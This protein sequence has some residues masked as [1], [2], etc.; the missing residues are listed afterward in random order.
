MHNI[1]KALLL[2]ILVLPAVATAQTA[3]EVFDS[4]YGADLKKV[5]GSPDTRDDLALAERM[6][7][8]IRSGK[9]D[10]QAAA[11]LC[12]KGFDLA[13]K[14]PGG[15][16]TAVA[17]M[18]E[19][20]ARKPDQK[21]PCLEKIAD[22]REKAFRLTP[23]AFRLEAGETLIDSLIEAAEADVKAGQKAQAGQMLDRALS[24]G[25]AIGSLRLSGLREWRR[26]LQA[27]ESNARRKARLQAQI[28]EFPADHAARADLVRLCLIEMDD[29]AE[30]RKYLEDASQESW[31]TYLPLACAAPDSLAEAACLEVADWYRGLADNA[32]AAG[33][34]A[35][36]VRAKGYYEQYL[37]MHT[38]ADLGHSKAALALQKIDEPLAAMEE[39]GLTLWADLLKPVLAQL[40]GNDRWTVKDGKARSSNN[41]AGRIDFAAP[42]DGGF[43]VMARFLKES[44]GDWG[45]AM[46]VGK[47]AAAVVYKERVTRRSADYSLEM[48]GAPGA[49]AVAL[50][51]ATPEEYLLHVIVALQGKNAE[52]TV[53]LNGKRALHW[54]G[55]A[56][57]VNMP[58][59]KWHNSRAIGL[60]T[61]GQ[62][63]LESVRVRA[64]TGKPFGSAATRPAGQPTS[65]PASQGS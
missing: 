44:G 2:G 49:P 10:A 36:L 28:K 11:L 35:M 43:E 65:Q 25:G 54:K 31:K 57:D 8:D 61:H 40:E 60:F 42:A 39:G 56:A 53:S 50:Q 22:V 17:M 41:R 55:D 3:T 20:L 47:N 62:V 63:T 46:P 38:D 21:A 37:R 13:M 19:L 45:V 4:I 34:L 30:A 52:L 59:W 29:S 24:T 16:E 51:L 26:R 64:L 5:S 23:Q 7:D 1:V 14:D 9:I 27:E 18:Q 15:N 12:G 33:K 32:S 6:L 48:E 58:S